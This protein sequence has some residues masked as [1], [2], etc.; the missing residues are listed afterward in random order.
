MNNSG[1]FGVMM[2]RKFAAFN[3]TIDRCKRN[4]KKVRTI[5][6]LIA[7]LVNGFIQ[8]EKFE[9]CVELS[10]SWGQE[11]CSCGSCLITLKKLCRD[12]CQPSQSPRL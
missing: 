3:Q 8:G 1:R 9:Q 7:D 6:Q 10:R 5:I 12:K 11:G 4:S 2:H